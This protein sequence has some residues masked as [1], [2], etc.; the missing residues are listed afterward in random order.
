V[1]EPPDLN[2]WLKG[3]PSASATPMMS[4]IPLE[5][6]Q[7]GRQLM[8]YQ[9]FYEKYQKVRQEPLHISRAHFFESQDRDR[10][11]CLLIKTCHIWVI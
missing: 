8:D 6:Y 10:P 5:V 3:H 7:N 11:Y 2:R 1:S 9:A 4:L